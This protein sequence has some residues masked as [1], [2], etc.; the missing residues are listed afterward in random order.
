[1]TMLR[2][3]IGFVAATMVTTGLFTAASSWATSGDLAGMGM[4]VSLAERAQMAGGDL[5]TAAP[6]FG[7]LIAIGGVIAFGLALLFGRLAPSLRTLMLIAAGALSVGFALSVLFFAL[8][9][10]SL[11]GAR[12]P[13]G[14]GLL[15][16]YGALGGAVF[17]AL[18][19]PG[20][21][22]AVARA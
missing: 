20:P 4:A 17:A 18:C 2:I 10:P 1:M 22:K 19:P 13:L 15:L 9:L 14:V 6:R 5:T 8:G 16:V 3:L 12:T 21:T 11:P 7:A